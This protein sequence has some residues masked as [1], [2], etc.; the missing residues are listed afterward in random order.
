MSGK[1]KMFISGALVL[2]VVFIVVLNKSDDEE[3]CVGQECEA[4]ETSSSLVNI[5]PLKF[6]TYLDKNEGRLIDLRTQGEH[7]AE[8]IKDSKVV[9]YYA[10][11]FVDQLKQLDKK[12]VYLIYCN[13]GNR[14]GA[15][16]AL[17]EQM[18]FEKVYNLEG[19]IQAW[20]FSGYSVIIGR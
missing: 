20:Q 11:D 1:V 17:M 13:S 2:L 9:D 3:G 12:E 4:G 14:S 10:S 15:T 16:L 5:T 18:G 19:G 8:R 6:K 7:D